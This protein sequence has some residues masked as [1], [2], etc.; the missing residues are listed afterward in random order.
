MT[1]YHQPSPQPYAPPPHYFT[2]GRRGSKYSCAHCGLGP[3]ARTHIPVYRDWKRT[4]LRVLIVV[5]VL[6][7]LPLLI[8]LANWVTAP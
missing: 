1:S 2:R 6:A 5:A 8:L 7:A 3:Q 4:W